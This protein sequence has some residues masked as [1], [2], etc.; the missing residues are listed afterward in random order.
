MIASS[1]DTGAAQ[2]SLAINV[3]DTDPVGM[4]QAAQVRVSCDVDVNAVR[5][6]T[7]SQL[8]MCV[9]CMSPW[10]DP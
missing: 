4:G 5:R 10:P 7:V 3:S 1:G 8:V 6:F 9:S 2:V